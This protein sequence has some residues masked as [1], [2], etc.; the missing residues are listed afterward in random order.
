[1]EH[2]EFQ[3]V[4]LQCQRCPEGRR[5]FKSLAQGPVSVQAD[6]LGDGVNLLA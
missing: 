6:L 2:E 4:Q 1:M 3:E 5:P